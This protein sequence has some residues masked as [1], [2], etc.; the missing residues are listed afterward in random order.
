MHKITGKIV[1][2][3]VS[4]LLYVLRRWNAKLFIRIPA[5][6]VKVVIDEDDYAFVVESVVHDYKFSQD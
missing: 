6:S 4:I 5:I 1:D 3:F 2:I